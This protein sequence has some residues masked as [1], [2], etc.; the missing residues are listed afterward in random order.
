MENLTKNQSNKLI[1]ASK[2]L[3]DAEKLINEATEKTEWNPAVSSLKSH[4]SNSINQLRS[5]RVDQFMNK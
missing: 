5:I 1:K 2:L 4:I 3:L